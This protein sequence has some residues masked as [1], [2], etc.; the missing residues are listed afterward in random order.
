[1][2]EDDRRS[3]PPPSSWT[4]SQA[5]TSTD[6][7]TQ[8][9]EREG[10]SPVPK[11]PRINTDTEAAPSSSSAFFYSA[12]APSSSVSARP[13]GHLGPASASEYHFPST[14]T[15]GEP[16]NLNLTQDVGTSASVDRRTSISSSTSTSGF[17]Q[18]PPPPADSQ[19]RH[20]MPHSPYAQ[21]NATLFP[22]HHSHTQPQSQ[23]P[24]QHQPQHQ[25][26]NTSRPPTPLT[27][28]V[29]LPLP[30]PVPS[31]G[32]YDRP[33]P[34]LPTVGYP[35]HPQHTHNTHQPLPIHQSLPMYTTSTA[36]SSSSTSTSSIVPS[37]A[38]RSYAASTSNSPSPPLQETPTSTT[39]QPPATPLSAEPSET[40]ASSTR[41]KG[42]HKGIPGPKARIPAEAKMM[43]A[44]HIIAK[45]VAMANLDELAQLTG[46]TKQQIKSQLVDNRQNVRKQLAEFAKGLQ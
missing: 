15:A 39:P 28:H 33:Q 46:L 13:S 40:K 24:H 34:V 8:R 41:G 45:G 10:A 26:P 1:M 6:S 7:E 22:P 30:F 2:S 20:R 19:D 25:F 43:I 37:Q 31:H 42:K 3:M 44:E 14:S 27:P 17:W 38:Q 35:Q 11:R 4:P 36:G 23:Q 32:E 18:P 5:S 9:L 12:S 16:R 29:S 21:T